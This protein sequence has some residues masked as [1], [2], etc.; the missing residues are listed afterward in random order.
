M[1]RF[2]CDGGPSPA[3]AREV[4]ACAPLLPQLLLAPTLTHI[5]TTFL[6]RVGVGDS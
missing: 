2:A 5:S 3:Q 6:L 4:G 1:M